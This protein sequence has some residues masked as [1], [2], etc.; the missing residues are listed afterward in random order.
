MPALSFVLALAT[1]PASLPQ[2]PP[3]AAA[4]T[5]PGR[6]LTRPLNVVGGGSS[7][8]ATVRMLVVLLDPSPELV[9]GGFV[10][11]FTAALAASA[12][13]LIRTRIGLAVTASKWGQSPS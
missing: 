4:V 13:P 5:E 12:R 1:A 10:D 9:K 2:S 3:T 8:E 7:R 11:V 6:T